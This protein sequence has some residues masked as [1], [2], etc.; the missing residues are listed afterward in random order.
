[1]GTLGISEIATNPIAA[2]V[3]NETQRLRVRY[4]TDQ[5]VLYSEVLNVGKP[6]RLLSGNYP[7]PGEEQ[8]PAPERLESSIVV[9]PLPQEDQAQ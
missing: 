2:S 7:P 6:A 8:E 9:E 4:T 1:M 5:N 3:G